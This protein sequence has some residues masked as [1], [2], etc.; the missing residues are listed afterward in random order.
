MSQPA[1][2][3]LVTEAA[4]AE[5]VGGLVT[6]ARLAEALE[7]F[8]PSAGAG[9]RLVSGTVTLS[10]ED[11]GLG[12]F[13][14]AT[15]AGATV[16]GVALSAGQMAAFWYL[17]G[18]WHVMVHGQDQAWRSTAKPDTR[19]AVTPT[20]PTFTN[21]TS[22]SG[23]TWTTP[24]QTGVVYTPAS[25]TGTAGQQ[26][27]VTATISDPAVYKFA[28]GAKTSWT[29]S[30]P[31]PSKPIADTFVGAAGP[32]AGHTTTTG[33]LAWEGSTN[34]GWN[35]TGDGKVV[36]SNTAAIC[37]N[38]LPT[39][40]NTADVSIEYSERTGRFQIGFGDHNKGVAMGVA[41]NGEILCFVNGSN[42]RSPQLWKTAPSGTLRFRYDGSTTTFWHDGVQVATK[43]GVTVAVDR[44]QIRS[45][46]DGPAKLSN[47]TVTP[48]A[49]A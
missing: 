10:T 37:S 45:N 40:T 47:L 15:Q 25:G 7:G 38:T 39:F 18:A 36:P 4:L 44:F 48:V 26:V 13:V 41:F 8:T 27:T 30:F 24:N 46:G 6:E 14:V 42:I 22:G 33:G 11:Q 29:Y 17:S 32:L 5:A 31:D 35:L 28:A 9:T 21:A 1:N 23:G 3:R 12:P 16:E 2:R 49:K 20:G 19:I 34:S 43:T